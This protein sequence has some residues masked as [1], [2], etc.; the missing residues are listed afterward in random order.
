MS[1]SQTTEWSVWKWF[2]CASNFSQKTASSRWQFIRQNQQNR[3][4]NETGAPKG[5]PVILR[6]LRNNPRQQV[7]S[8]LRELEG[9]AGL[10]LAVLLALDHARV[11]GQEA[12]LLEHAAQLRLEIR[13][14]L[15]DAV[16][17]RAG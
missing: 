1:E 14:S 6:V 11:A 13:Q 8:A 16:T 15:G 17:H 12:T 4:Q 3:I 2:A 5:T 9:P 10:G 7:R